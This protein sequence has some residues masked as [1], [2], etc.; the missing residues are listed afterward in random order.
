MAQEKE[1]AILSQMSAAMQTRQRFN[2]V[3]S[4]AQQQIQQNPQQQTLT[5]SKTVRQAYE[6]SF[7]FINSSS[8]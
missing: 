6:E 4:L 3:L 7:N 5:A 1:K 2:P 8:N